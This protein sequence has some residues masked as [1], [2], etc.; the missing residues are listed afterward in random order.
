MNVLLK[1]VNMSPLG[2]CLVASIVLLMI[3]I[4]CT[5]KI[6]IGPVS[7]PKI[8]SPGRVLAAVTGIALLCLFI[9]LMVSSF[10]GLF[11]PTYLKEGQ[12]SQVIPF[13]RVANAN[14]TD[15]VILEQEHY[16]EVTLADGTK[17]GVYVG[18]INPIGPNWL[19]IAAPKKLS[20]E[21]GN[22]YSEEEAQRLII[23]QNRLLSAQVLGGYD[24]S[25]LLGN[26]PIH[27]EV[28]KVHWFLLDS[29]FM[30]LR[31]T[32]VQ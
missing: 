14:P 18:D 28:I 4:F 7:L 16:K 26:R 8:D 1:I 5:K 29:D 20:L 2:L 24:S 11:A 22:K 32:D 27:I 9:Y 23:P 3:S 15:L 17:L 6:T 19:L 21:S 13:I 31:V 25:I 12:S 30:E 10:S